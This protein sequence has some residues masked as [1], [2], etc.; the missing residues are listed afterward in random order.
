MLFDAATK[1][2]NK[3]SNM[4]Q[5]LLT[6]RYQHS[7]VKDHELENTAYLSGGNDKDGYYK[8]V[9]SVNCETMY[10]TKLELDESECELPPNFHAHQPRH[11]P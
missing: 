3:V 2:L 4:E 6:K 11:F 10:F 5:K 8:D 7:F 9:Y 1:T